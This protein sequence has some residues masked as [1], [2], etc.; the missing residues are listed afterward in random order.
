MVILAFFV[1]ALSIFAIVQAITIHD[2]KYESEQWRDLYETRR[3]SRDRLQDDYDAALSELEAAKNDAANAWSL[4]TSLRE[5]NLELHNRNQTLI[6]DVKGKKR[7]I[8]IA[9][10]ELVRQNVVIKSLT[11]K[12]DEH[13][14]FVKS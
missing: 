3:D 13:G 1:I 4:N 12:R 6:A 8:E 14:R 5:R 10:R 7:F 9:S 11:R 2:L